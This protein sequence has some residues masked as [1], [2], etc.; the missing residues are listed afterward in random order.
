MLPPLSSVPPPCAPVNVAAQDSSGP[1]QRLFLPAPELLRPPPSAEASLSLLGANA[2]PPDER[3]RL[4]AHLGLQPLAFANG[5]AISASH[6]ELAQASAA[7]PDA[8]W[9]VRQLRFEVI[10]ALELV[11]THHLLDRL[12]ATPCSSNWRNASSETERFT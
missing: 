12:Y 3:A 11:N 8:F 7:A 4:T 10:F 2:S 1:R 9:K 5:T 6:V